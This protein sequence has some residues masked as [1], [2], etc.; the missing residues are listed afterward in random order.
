MKVFDTAKD[1]MKNTHNSYVGQYA[2][3]AVA[4]ETVLF[5]LSLIIG[6]AVRSAFGST[7]GY[8]VCIFLAVSIV[9]MMASF[10]LRT[11]GDRKIYAPTC[12]D[13]GNFV[14]PFLYWKL[15]HPAC[16]CDNK[17]SHAPA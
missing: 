5:G 6:L 13:C 7:M 4:I 11:D 3:I 17:P 12:Y 15:L 1:T 16:C 2:A 8:I 14:C 9:V 10:Y